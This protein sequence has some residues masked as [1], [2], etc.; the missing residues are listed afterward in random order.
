MTGERNAGISRIELNVGE[1]VQP[2][3]ET[4]PKAL[5]DTTAQDQLRRRRHVIA[6]KQLE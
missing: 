3:K 2:A 5:A 6:E 1:V 4:Q